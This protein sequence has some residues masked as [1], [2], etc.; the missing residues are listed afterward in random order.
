MDSIDDGIDNGIEVA[1]GKL[2]YK[3]TTNLS[4]RVGSLN[5]SWN[6]E[7]T[8]D[9]MNG[10]FREAML[11]TGEEFS[12]Y[13]LRLANSWWPARSIVQTALTREA[14]TPSLST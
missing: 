2:N 14:R 4:S 10:R 3:V 12:G 8:D 11:L 5:P 1:E 6:E 9:V 13:V 7:Q